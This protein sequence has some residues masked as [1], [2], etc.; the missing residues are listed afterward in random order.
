MSE[1]KQQEEYRNYKEES[2]VGKFYKKNHE[3]Q[4]YSYVEQLKKEI[5][6]VGKFKYDVFQV[7]ELMDEIIDESDP[8]TQQSQIIHAL[9][10]GEACRKLIPE[11]DWFHLL[12]FI[13][14]LGKVIA[15]PKMYNLPQWAVVGDTFPLGCQFHTKC[16]FPQF[17]E[18]NEDYTNPLYN[19]KLGIY[20]EGCGFDNLQFSFGHDEYMYQVLLQNNTKLPEEALYVVRYH[21][22]YPWHQDLAYDYFANSKDHKLLSLL[23]TFQK[24]DLYSKLEE[25]LDVEKLLPYYKGLIS[26]YFPNTELLW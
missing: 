21:S 10:A 1:T 5:F 18:S 22:F 16:V 20:K 9:Q 2:R 6:P 23:R 15:H 13:H 7:I 25:E 3:I 4:N 8:D 24:C 26:K 17:F 14:D 11:T 19:T 12:G